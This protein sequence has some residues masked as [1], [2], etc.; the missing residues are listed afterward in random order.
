MPPFLCI[1]RTKKGAFLF[2]LVNEGALAEQFV[3][4]HVLYLEE[5]RETPRLNYWLR[6]GKRA[7]AHVAGAAIGE[8]SSWT[9]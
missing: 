3:G 5:G 9:I 7:N 6:E 1:I 4:Q 2:I 8:T